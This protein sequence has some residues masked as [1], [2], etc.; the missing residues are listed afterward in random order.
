MARGVVIDEE[1]MFRA[2][3]EK[4]IA[5]AAIDVWYDYKPEPD[6][7]G[8][9]Y[10]FNYPFNELDNIVLSPH[11]GASPLDNLERWQEVVENIRRFASGRTDF[12]NIVDL[13]RGY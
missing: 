5:A 1:G 10:P 6:D 11:R 3:K 12:L 8:K 9:K 13:E 7:A 2:L 4:V